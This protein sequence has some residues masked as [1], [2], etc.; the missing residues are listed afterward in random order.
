MNNE[1]KINPLRNCQS[2]DNFFKRKIL[3]CNFGLFLAVSSVHFDKALFFNLGLP[4]GVVEEKSGKA[5]QISFV[6]CYHCCESF[7]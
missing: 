2:L 4:K 5:S 6:M 7:I 3:L 1:G